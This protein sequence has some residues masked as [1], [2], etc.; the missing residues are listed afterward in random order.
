MKFIA[1]LSIRA[2][3]LTLLAFSVTFLGLLGGFSSFTIL[4]LSGLATGV[5][6]NEFETVR[7]VSAIQAAVRDARGFEKDVLL[8]M[9]DE[10]ET[11]KYT[12][13]WTAEIKRARDGIGLLQQHASTHRPDPSAEKVGRLIQGMSEGVTDYEK[14]FQAVLSKMAHGELHDTWAASAAMAPVLVQL[15]QLDQSLTTLAQM[16]AENANAERVQ[17]Q[18]AGHNA[19]WLVLGA[20]VLVALIACS[21]ALATI[22]SI[23]RPLQ[24]L[25]TIAASWGSGDLS[26]AMQAQG[27]D[28]VAQVMRDLATMQSQLAQLVSQIQSGVEI[29]NKNTREIAEANE[30]LSGRT[31]RAVVALQKTTASVSQLSGAVKITAESA[32][33][34]V[35]SV[36]DTVHLAQDGGGIVGRVIQTMHQINASSGQITDIIGVIDAIAFQTNLLALNAAVEAARAG[37]QGRGFAVVAAEVRALAARSSVAAREIKSIIETSLTHIASGTDL[38]QQAGGKMQEILGSVSGVSHVINAIQSAAEEQFEGIDLISKSMQG[39]DQATQE[40]AAMVEASAEGTAVLA[41]EV[42]HLRGALGTFK[43][44]A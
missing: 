24:H 2:R 17:L 36:S 21:F 25:Q 23:L 19:P 41:N 3:L 34:A 8:T 28:E 14:G 26:L 16:T 32:G 12:Q 9:G 15:R 40:N 43:L 31:E 38:V 6:D 44:A 30:Q 22:R 7:T 37:E 29:V 42:Q 10:A 11:D 13:R 20:T 27:S 1:Q 35:A 5:I 33:Q 4:R 39:I 18:Q